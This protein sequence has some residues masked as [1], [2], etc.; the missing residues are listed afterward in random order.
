MAQRSLHILSADGSWAICHSLPATDG[1]SLSAGQIYHL[2]PSEQYIEFHDILA[3]RPDIM[4]IR[5]WVLNTPSSQ[6]RCPTNLLPPLQHLFH[7][8]LCDQQW[9][10][11]SPLSVFRVLLQ[12]G[13]AAVSSIALH[14][15][16][17]ILH[18]LPPSYLTL[19]LTPLCEKRCTILHWHHL[20]SVYLWIL[21]PRRVGTHTAQLRQC[22]SVIIALG[23][24]ATWR[25]QPILVLCLTACSQPLI[26][27]SAYT[28][29]SCSSG[30]H[31]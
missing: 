16:R 19:A 2:V 3:S 14:A 10:H 25:S 21:S 30:A 4:L 11:T 29:E 24:P 26:G 6:L 8:S 13:H 1:L 23:P 22:L 17:R 27:S 18:N 5:Y 31:L 20:C 7:T 12:D 15:A 9:H 28:A